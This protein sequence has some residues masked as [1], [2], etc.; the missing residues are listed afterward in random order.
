MEGLAKAFGCLR[1]REPF[2]SLAIDEEK[3]RPDLVRAIVE[4]W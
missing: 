3:T 2:G 1:V 4:A